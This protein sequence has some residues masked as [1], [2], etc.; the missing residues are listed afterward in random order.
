[1]RPR[2]P[3]ELAVLLARLLFLFLS[4]L[5]ILGGSI[6]VIFFLVALATGTGA[7]GPIMFGIAALAV[8]VSLLVAKANA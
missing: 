2:N 4:A 3:T 1:M 7:I 8:I 6:L 5:G